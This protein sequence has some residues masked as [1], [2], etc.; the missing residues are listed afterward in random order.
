MAEV[1]LQHHA[2]GRT[3]GV[4]A[5]AE[6]LEAAGH[7]VHVPD[8]YDG[9]LFA[10]LA[11]GV[12][13]VQQVGMDEIVHRG[14]RAAEGLPEDLVHIGFSLGVMPAQKLAQ[15]HSGALAAV[16]VAACL[17]PTAFA[18]HWPAG[19]PVQVHGMDGDARFVDDGDLEAA[20]DL[21]ATADDA[22]LFL[23]EGGGHLFFDDRAEDHDPDATALL[24]ERVLALLDRV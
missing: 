23:Y 13:H 8:L 3:T 17:P 21:V 22:E 16:L 5:F 11:A 2:L 9:A 6:Q 14:V 19:V 12:A 15:T 4:V 24:V 18:D 7:G 20:E 1:L 10:D